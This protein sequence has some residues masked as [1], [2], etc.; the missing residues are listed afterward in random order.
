[1]GKSMRLRNILDRMRGILEE[2]NRLHSELDKL[3][4]DVKKML[5]ELEFTH[6]MWHKVLKI[7]YDPCDEPYHIK[8]AIY[9]E[10]I[11]SEHPLEVYYYPVRD[12][13]KL[14]DAL[15]KFNEEVR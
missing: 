12:L 7:S 13:P 10:G 8:I 2:L 1:M 4:S 15:S 9:A 14:I 11:D 6:Q 3:S 5:Q